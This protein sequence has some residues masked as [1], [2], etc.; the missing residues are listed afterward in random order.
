MDATTM[1]SHWTN[2]SRAGVAGAVE[3]DTRVSLVTSAT[4]L[5]TGTAGGA[6]AHC[7]DY[8]TPIGLILESLG[9]A[10]STRLSG[11]GLSPS[12]QPDSTA[13]ASAS[14]TTRTSL[15]GSLHTAEIPHGGE[16]I[17][18]TQVPRS[19]EESLPC[20]NYL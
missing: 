14:P 13:S 7:K 5:D 19:P 4:G 15:R 6:A 8:L 9:G 2:V 12:M 11:L 20:V 18:L 10:G 17:E 3:S 1:M 16:G